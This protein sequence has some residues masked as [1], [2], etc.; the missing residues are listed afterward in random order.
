M[1]IKELT[2]ELQQIKEFVSEEFSQ[3]N[4]EALLWKPSS[5]SWSIAECLK[6]IVIAN[7]LYLEDIQK[8][9][10]KAEVRTI[11]H[12]IKLSLMGRVFL[13]FVDPKY[14]WKVKAPNIF[15]PIKGHKVTNGKQV[16]DDYLKLQD[17]LIKVAV[18]AA[19]Y[20]HANIYITSPLSKLLRFNIGEQLFI[21]MRHE[22]RHLNQ[23]G[24][25]KSKFNQLI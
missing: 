23:A 14:T 5:N 7:T 18:K 21:M 10:E 17:D 19:G 11:E 25:V 22:K 16:L 12:P 1:W 3:L 8:Q 4:E 2:H 6:H 15:K 9:L 13:L 20:D 24:T